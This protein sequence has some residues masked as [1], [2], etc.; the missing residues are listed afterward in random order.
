MNDIKIPS[1]E[2]VRL[3]KGMT[4][5]KLN[6]YMENA[7][8]YSFLVYLRY[9]Y[10][11][12]KEWTYA[13]ECASWWSDGNTVNWLDD[14]YEGQQNVEYLAITKIGKNRKLVNKEDS[15]EW[16]PFVVENNE[17]ISECP[18]QYEKILVTD[19]E[20]IWVDLW[21]DCGDYFGLESNYDVEGLAWMPL[22]N[23]Y[24]G[25]QHETNC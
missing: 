4:D 20:D 21:D 14:W 22:P 2:F 7:D 10:D 25:N 1:I 8:D 6:H 12:E 19:G 24:K 15:F 16:I 13:T 5:K 23:P 9:K 3:K 17:I 18:E 11:F